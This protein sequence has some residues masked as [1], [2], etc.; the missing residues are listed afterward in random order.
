[1]KKFFFTLCAL[2]CGLLATAATVQLP[3]TLNKANVNAVSSDMTYY[4]DVYFELNKKG[5][6]VPTAWA[7]WSVQLV[8]PGQFIVTESG[9]YTDGHQYKLELLKGGNVVDSLVMSES[10][11]TG[12]QTFS[13]LW[14]LS[15]V[16]ADTYTLRVKAKLAYGHPNLKSLQ[17]EYFGD[18]IPEPEPMPDPDPAGA[19]VNYTADN[20]T[21]FPNPERGFITMLEA[22]QGRKYYAVKGKESYLTNHA[23]N[24][25][26]SLILVLY[27]LE[28]F[29]NTAVLPDSVLNAFDEDMAILRNYGM[30]AI[31]RFAYTN[32]T[33]TVDNVRSAHD[34]PLSIIEQHLAQLKSHWQNNAD[35]IFVFQAG[36]IGAYGEWHYTDNFGN[37]ES[38]INEARRAFLDTLMRAT[39]Q[40][41]CVQIRTPLYKSEYIGSNTAILY[42]EAYTGTNKARLGHHNDAFL[43]H[44]DNMGTYKDTALQKPYVAQ[45]TYYVPI[46]GESDITDTIQALEDASHENTIAEMSRLHWTFIQS[47]YSRVVTDTWRKNAEHTFDELN[48][49]LGYRYQ[50]VNG[51]YTQSAAPGGNLSVYMN[52]KNAGFAPLYNER[53]VYIVLKSNANTYRLRMS[54]DPR[55]WRPNGVTTTVSEVLTLPDNIVPGTYQLYLHMPD[56]Y[57]SIADDPRYAVRFA[58]TGVWDAETGLNALNATLTVTGEAPEPEPSY[59]QLPATLNKANVTTYCEDMTWYGDENEYFDFG[60]GTL[61]CCHNLDRWAEWTVKLKYPGQY[62]VTEEYDVLENEGNAQGHQWRLVLL[63]N[64]RDSVA[65]YETTAVWK[66][67]RARTETTKWNLSSLNAGIYTLR[68]KNI[69]KWS[70]PK[71]KRITLE[72]DGDLPTALEQVSV[73]GNG[74]YGPADMRVYDLCGREV[75]AMSEHLG[76]GIFIVVV[77][78]QAGKVM[79]P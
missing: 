58:N 24:D 51:T 31:V 53:P 48:R 50:L 79:I 3:T 49:R 54:A 70:N 12:E 57:A 6:Q 18:I 27:Y 45:D 44:A 23:T 34:A 28:E 36:F 39:P 40:D 72:Y 68:V 77:N 55:R 73:D 11:S 64:S 15:A 37:T 52:I 38:H 7:E 25:K 17:F 61:G 65:G 1:M 41:R 59:V 32:Q 8:N 42:S 29:A 9:Y 43:Y 16:A 35:V 69:M 21:I 62:I 10:Y 46:G 67:G 2:G 26:G 60:P 33:Y 71:L 30:K 74:I 5:Y 63:D 22:K 66:S 4:N 56:A 14:D 47:G 75:T 78:G 19:Q 76:R 13:T 20:T